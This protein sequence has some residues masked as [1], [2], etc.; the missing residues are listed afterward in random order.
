MYLKKSVRRKRTSRK[1]LNKRVYKKRTYKKRTY[2]KRTYKKRTY[3]NKISTIRKKQHGGLNSSQIN[4]ATAGKKPLAENL[5]QLQNQINASRFLFHWNGW[6]FQGD[7]DYDIMYVLEEPKLAISPDIKGHGKDTSD[8]IP[9]KRLLD[10]DGMPAHDRYAISRR[11]EVVITFRCAMFSLNQQQETKPDKY[12]YVGEYDCYLVRNSLRKLKGVRSGVE[13]FPYKLYKT[14]AQLPQQAQQALT[15]YPRSNQ[16][17]RGGGGDGETHTRRAWGQP[18]PREGGSSGVPRIVGSP[19]QALTQRAEPSRDPNPPLTPVPPPPPRQP[20]AARPQP[21]EWNEPELERSLQPIRVRARATQ[22]PTQ[23]S[24]EPEPEVARPPHR[25]RG[26]PGGPSRAEP[27]RDPN[28]P[29]TPVPASPRGSPTALW[30]RPRPDGAAAAAQEWTEPEPEQEFF[31]SKP[32]STRVANP[33]A[34]PA[35]PSRGPNQPLTPVTPVTQ[36]PP[37]ARN[38]LDVL[39]G[40]TLKEL[41]NHAMQM[42]V[43]QVVA[44]HVVSEFGLDGGRAEEA[45]INLIKPRLATGSPASMRQ[46]PGTPSTLGNLHEMN[47]LTLYNLAVK[48]G[49]PMEALQQITKEAYNLNRGFNKDALIRLIKGTQRGARPVQGSTANQPAQREQYQ[50]QYQ[51]PSA[52]LPV[53]EKAPMQSEP[54]LPM[55]RM[56]T[57]AE[58]IERSK[59][60]LGAENS[61]ALMQLSLLPLHPGQP[62]YHHPHYGRATLAGKLETSSTNQP[63][64]RGQVEQET[65][66]P[67]FPSQKTKPEEKIFYSNIIDGTRKLQKPSGE[68][69]NLNMFQQLV[70]TKGVYTDTQVWLGNLGKHK[71]TWRTLG[72]CSQ[73]LS[74]LGIKNLDKLDGMSSTISEKSHPSSD[75]SSG[76]SSGANVKSNEIREIDRGLRARSFVDDSSKASPRMRVDSTIN[77]PAYHISRPYIKWFPSGDNREE[78]FRPNFHNTFGGDDSPVFLDYM[79]G[80]IN[81]IIKNGIVPVFN[82]DEAHF[83]VKAK[84]QEIV[85]NGVETGYFFILDEQ[86]HDVLKDLTERLGEH[87]QTIAVKAAQEHRRYKNSPRPYGRAEPTR[88]SDGLPVGG[89]PEPELGPVSAAGQ[90]PGPEPFGEESEP[91]PEPSVSE[92]EPSVS[93]SREKTDAE[94]LEE[95]E[96]EYENFFEDDGDDQ[97]AQA[98]LRRLKNLN[99]QNGGFPTPT[100]EELEQ[101]LEEL[102]TMKPVPSGGDTKEEKAEFE[103]LLQERIDAL[104]D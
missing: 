101:R 34:S 4:Q 96:G 10:I 14:P 35:S 100:I 38:T 80:A 52:H 68:G 82:L 71:N 89:E 58:R 97:E 21:Q 81:S 48:Q 94:I 59:A 12:T 9:D 102:M 63:A 17:L 72:E 19:A 30:R 40:M 98:L 2:K 13:K 73:E 53:A 22:V 24:N 78:L 5:C 56:A 83:T 46:A 103:R 60:M 8:K 57:A 70:D 18:R 45:L 27:S 31:M 67:Q 64:Q 87:W 62:G 41:Y 79:E 50:E 26:Q 54:N 65:V 3:N 42:G 16:N 11:H 86:D 55:A 74:A 20:A 95:L 51:E 84:D 90:G 61:E 93:G 85:A 99:L 32:R 25:T 77:E 23:G 49:V 69:I 15:F 76:A 1:K 36:V 33:A 66:A 91:E 37:P 88:Q 75:T 6:T 43:N 28:Q 29:L 104:K 39:Q 47:G 7:K 44:D 92:P